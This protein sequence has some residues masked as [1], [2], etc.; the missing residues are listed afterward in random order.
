MKSAKSAREMAINLQSLMAGKLSWADGMCKGG[1]T[2]GNSEYETKGSWGYL[3]LA[4]VK[5]SL[6]QSSR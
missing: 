6:S 5:L 2:E 4:T 1:V 3:R